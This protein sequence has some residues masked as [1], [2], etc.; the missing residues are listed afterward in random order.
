MLALPVSACPHAVTCVQWRVL[1]GREIYRM[2][3]F[4]ERT[5]LGRESKAAPPL[6]RGPPFRCADSE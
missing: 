3:L 5:R 2:G 6:C 4:I 1:E